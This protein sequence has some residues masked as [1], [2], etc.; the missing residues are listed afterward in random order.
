MAGPDVPIRTAVRAVSRT[1]TGEP[2][3]AR[4]GTEFSED[5]NTEAGGPRRTTE[6]AWLPISRRR[7]GSPW[8]SVV[9]RALRVK[10]FLC[11]PRTRRCHVPAW[12]RSSA[13]TFRFVLS[14]CPA[15]A[16]ARS[17]GTRFQCRRRTSFHCRLTPGGTVRRAAEQEIWN[18]RCTP[19]NTDG[20]EFG[21]FDHGKNRW[22]IGLD[23]PRLRDGPAPSVCIGVHRWRNFLACFATRRTRLRGSPIAWRPPKPHAPNQRPTPPSRMS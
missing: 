5:F 11:C 4:A 14:P 22:T 16:S 13:A 23:G 10:S 21:M 1:H 20:P 2:G 18:H 9:L 17:G 8:S 19:M 7:H 3:G 15:P 6:S 12:C